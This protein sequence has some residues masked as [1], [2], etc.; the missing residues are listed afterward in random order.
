MMAAVLL[1]V[2]KSIW[3]CLL[4]VVILRFPFAEW[5]APSVFGF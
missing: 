3:Y 4:L 2:E 5:Q 1:K